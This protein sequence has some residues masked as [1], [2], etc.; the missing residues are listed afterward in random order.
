MCHC[1]K[2][3]SALRET[4]RRFLRKLPTCLVVLLGA[5]RGLSQPEEPL[6]RRNGWAR[7]ITPHPFWNLHFEQDPIIAGFLR[8]E[9]P[10]RFD[11]NSY[12]VDP[13]DLDA[14][15]SFPF[16]FT[17]DLTAIV[18]STQLDHL[19]EYLR[20]GGF[21]Y[22]EACLDHRVTRGFGDFLSRHSALFAKLLPGSEFRPLA[23]DHAIFQTYFRVDENQLARIDPR[24]DPER[25]K[26]AP[27]ALYGI[28]QKNRLI[29]L[30][31][32]DHL[33]CEWIT[34]PEKIPLAIRQIANLYVYAMT[35]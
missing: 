9:V 13:A 8:R 29:S 17:N 31:S 20:R 34:K 5:T 4:R 12:T 16:I 32:L 3:S 22:I 14:L 7:L 24:V 30:L 23:P 26:N 28:F 6:A 15:C 19:Q 33:Q 11:S 25:W 21:F 27:P 10:L 2:V 35:R 1:C 18:D